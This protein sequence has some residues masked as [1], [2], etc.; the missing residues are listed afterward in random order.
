MPDLLHAGIRHQG[1]G[2]QF[3]LAVHHL[4]DIR[5]QLQIHHCGFTTA[6]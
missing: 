4:D 5:Q 1:R 6:A 3:H 2:A